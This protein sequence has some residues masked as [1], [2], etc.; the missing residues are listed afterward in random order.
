MLHVPGADSMPPAP[1]PD[2][3]WARKE[4]STVTNALARVHERTAATIQTLETENATLRTRVD[5]LEDSSGEIRRLRAENARLMARLAAA[6]PEREEL[7]RERDASLRKLKNMRKVV[8]DLLSEGR[9]GD[10]FGIGLDDFGDGEES[11]TTGSGTVRPNATIAQSEVDSDVATEVTVVHASSSQHRPSASLSAQSSATLVGNNHLDSVNN[12]PT[13]LGPPFTDS[14]HQTPAPRHPISQP[15]PRVLSAA[16]L[17][18]SPVRRPSSRNASLN[19]SP[20][21]SDGLSV[22]YEDLQASSSSAPRGKWRIHFAKPPVGT[23]TIVGPVQFTDLVEKLDLDEET[24]CS[25]DNLESLPRDSVRLEISGSSAFLYD[26]VLL[27]TPTAAY[28]V[29]WTSSTI[30]RNVS[31]YIVRASVKHEALHTY[32]HS[33][34]KGGWF[35][36]GLHKWSI[37]NMKSIWSMLSAQAQK[38]LSVRRS[39]SASSSNLTRMIDDGELVQLAIELSAAAGPGEIQIAKKLRAS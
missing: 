14:R 17:G 1:H 24:I 35:Y 3:E 18:G 21:M 33:T 6:A 28:V 11:T 10:D 7:V 19:L 31:T 12:T 38:A 39:G 4:L 15:F 23:K 34:K 25:L 9:I 30:S 37:S 2:I 20:G 29:D 26:P 16:N 5:E 36:L 32:M 22:Q 8:R 27:E 13:T